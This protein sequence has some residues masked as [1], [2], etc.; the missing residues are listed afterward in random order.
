MELTEVIEVIADNAFTIIGCI[1]TIITVLTKK[2]PTENQ[3]KE[4]QQDK[5]I[6]KLNA[7]KKEGENHVQQASK[8]A[9][10]ITALEK[11]IEQNA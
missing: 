4:S 7:L 1:V 5:R 11:E 9:E 3:V 10:E 6:K 2:F 8:I